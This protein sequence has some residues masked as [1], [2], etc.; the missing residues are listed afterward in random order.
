MLDARKFDSG[1]RDNPILLPMLKASME[2]V[3]KMNPKSTQQ[4]LKSLMEPLLAWV[5]SEDG[6]KLYTVGPG[7]R[8]SHIIGLVPAVNKTPAQMVQMAE[9]LR[10]NHGIVVAVRSGRFRIAPYLDNTLEDVQSLID[11]LKEIMSEKTGAA[12]LP[13][14]QSVVSSELFDL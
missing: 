14:P 11:G 1:G 5:K 8:A 4:T 3:V 12:E 6:S 10:A 13:S 7:P 2:S 9:T